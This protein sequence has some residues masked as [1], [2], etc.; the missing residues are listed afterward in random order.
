MT[1]E[2]AE[3][4]EAYCAALAA[5]VA[6]AADDGTSPFR[7]TIIHRLEERVG[8]AH[9]VR[10]ALPLIETDY[11]T[12]I[13]HDLAFVQEVDFAPLIEVL[14]NNADRVKYIGLPGAKHIGIEHH[15]WSHYNVRIAPTLEFGPKLI[16][17]IYWYDKT[18]V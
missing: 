14:R 13:Q 17:I 8:F 6:A 12:V 9:A 11:I 10:L 4:Y 2:A 7:N 15:T 18:H 1:A 5:L 3:K 16:P